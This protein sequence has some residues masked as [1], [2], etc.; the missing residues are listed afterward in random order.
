MTFEY[1]LLHIKNV[2]IEDLTDE[3]QDGY[4]YEYENTVEK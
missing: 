4:Y 2:Y 1:W 3:E